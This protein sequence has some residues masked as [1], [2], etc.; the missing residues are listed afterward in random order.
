MAKKIRPALTLEQKK[1]LAYKRKKGVLIL[2]IV[3][4]VA[5]VGVEIVMVVAELIGLAG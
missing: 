5:L 2:I 3:L 4:L 1:H